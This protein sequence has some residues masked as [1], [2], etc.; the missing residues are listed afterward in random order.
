MADQGKKQV[1]IETAFALFNE[2][3]FH[4]TGIDTIMRESGVSKTTLY[5]YF[6]TKDELILAVLKYRHAQLEQ[7]LQGAIDDA[8][9]QQPNADSSVHALSVFDGL[10]EWFNS[11]QFYGCNFINA[12][13]EFSQHN[14]PIHQYAD[15]HKR[16]IMSFVAKVLGKGHES[17]AQQLSLLMDGAIVAAHV[18][19][20]K[21]AAE[22]AKAIAQKL[23]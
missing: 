2:F 23:I 1:L 5:K 12:S 17:L 9:S 7:S 22:T 3:G 11:P 14:H 10:A 18:R 21:S 20:D 19:G 15:F 4:A 16:W 8:I 6:R 13:A